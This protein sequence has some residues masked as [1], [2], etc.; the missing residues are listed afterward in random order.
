MKSARALAFLMLPLSTMMPVA[1][2]QTVTGSIT[3]TVVDAGD[4]GPARIDDE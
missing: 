3:G 1:N 4:A 2:S